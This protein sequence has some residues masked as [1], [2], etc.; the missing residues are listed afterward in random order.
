VLAADANANV[1][2][3]YDHDLD[4]TF[5]EADDHDDVTPLMGT[6]PARQHLARSSAND[7]HHCQH[8]VTPGG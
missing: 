7:D 1:L 5:E 4:A 6:D 3:R 8:L 2:R